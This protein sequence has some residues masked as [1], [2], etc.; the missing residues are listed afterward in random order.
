MSEIAGARSYADVV[1]AH[2]P[3]LLRLAVML[4]GHPAD[5][6]DL[7]QSTLLRAVRHA[8]RV[9]A[10]DAPAAYLRQIML[11][12]NL[13]RGRRLSR[14]IRTVSTEAIPAGSSADPAVPSGAEAVDRRDE[15]WAWLAELRPK[16]RAVLALR[17][18]EDL[19]DSEIATVLGCTEA[20]VR[21]HAFRGLASLR[22]RLASSGGS[23]PS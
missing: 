22:E 1:A 7:L 21:S 2:A 15:T 4:T 11:N 12:E 9:A 5:A 3:S 16:Q 10:M 8:D 23:D 17:Y 6:E 20:T 14:R 19:P 13:S 18:Y